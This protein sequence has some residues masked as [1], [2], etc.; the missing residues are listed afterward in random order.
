MSFDVEPTQVGR[1]RPR[2]HVAAVL[3]AAVAVVAVAVATGSGAPDSTGLP[4]PTSAVAEAA[5][6]VPAPSSAP[7]RNDS[8]PGLLVPPPEP[9]AS[10]F[11]ASVDSGP[12]RLPR[13]LTCHGVDDATCRRIALAGV[14]VLPAHL[15]RVT[16]VEAWASMLCADDLECPRD[17]LSDSTPLGS[18]IVSFADGGAQAWVNVVSPAAPSAGAQRAGGT[19]AWV[20][21]WQP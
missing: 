6:A 16:R 12:L 19:I 5:T 7:R 8:N 13:R 20:V 3:A 11:D 17:V 1:G 2:L 15:P 9:G 21:R 10:P 4:F 18:A 14:A